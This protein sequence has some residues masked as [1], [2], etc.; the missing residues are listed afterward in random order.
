MT[1]DNKLDWCL[2]WIG[3]CMPSSDWSSWT[4]AVM[5]AA[6]V[7]AA[8]GVVWW[9]IRIKNR[10]DLAA[11]KLAGAGFLVFANQTIGGLTSVTSALDERAA[12][13]CRPSHAISHI[14]LTL[15]SLPL[16][17]RDDLVALNLALPECS[18]A[19][20]RASHSVQQLRSALEFL[21]NVENHQMD[22]RE[23][24]S[25]LSELAGV[26]AKTFIVVR[27]ELDR[28]CPK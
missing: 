26:A 18:V 1:T 9:Q 20:L 8:I 28:F 21:S 15:S 6:A 23:T 17:S 13:N 5:S 7:F 25:P 14:L 3:P 4:Q 22:Q 27:E 10:Q 16:P 24:F 12:G 2:F 19:A 11:A